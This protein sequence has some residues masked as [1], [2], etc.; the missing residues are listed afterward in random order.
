[1]G[2]EDTAGLRLCPKQLSDRSPAIHSTFYGAETAL[3]E[4]SIYDLINTVA[5]THSICSKGAG[6]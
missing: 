6:F 1:M 2:K 3:G 5:P 4:C